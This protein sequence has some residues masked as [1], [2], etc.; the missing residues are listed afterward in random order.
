MIKVLLTYLVSK[1]ETC[2]LST[3]ETL[4]AIIVDSSE[5]I[6][7]FEQNGGL[8]LVCCILKQKR[9]SEAIAFKCIEL[10]RV[11]LHPEDDY[12]DNE[13]KLDAANKNKMIS[14]NLG[15]DFLKYLN[16]LIN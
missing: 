5:N 16:D 9:C 6:R 14:D 7:L 11:Y 12:P 10:I 15:S 2:I 13:H 4:Q 8:Q 1:D 3:L